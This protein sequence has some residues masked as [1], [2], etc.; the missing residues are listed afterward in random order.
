MRPVV[1]GFWG[2][3]AGRGVTTP[4][5]ETLPVVIIPEEG[6]RVPASPPTK[7]EICLHRRFICKGDT[8][9]HAQGAYPRVALG[10]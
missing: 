6:T 2:R 1:A 9:I 8:S 4:P 10:A 5:Q 3:D 7:C